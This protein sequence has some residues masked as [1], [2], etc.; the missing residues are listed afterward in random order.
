MGE[1]LPMLADLLKRG[2]SVEQARNL[3]AVQ[4]KESFRLVR[5]YQTWFKTEEGRERLRKVT[6]SFRELGVEPPFAGIIDV[7]QLFN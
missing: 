4:A 1:H 5:L 7:N 2:F 3:L 6:L